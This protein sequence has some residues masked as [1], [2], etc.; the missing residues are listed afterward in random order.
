M[1]D[2]VVE[3][4]TGPTRMDLLEM[5]LWLKS[6]EHRFYEERGEVK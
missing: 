2:V 4:T 6:E 5:S 1:N 3:D